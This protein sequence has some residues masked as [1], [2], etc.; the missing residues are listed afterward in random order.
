MRRSLL[1]VLIVLFVLVTIG[2]RGVAAGP[3]SDDLAKCLVGSTTVDERNMFVRWMFSVMA[4]HPAVKSVSAMTDAQRAELSQS[5]G[6]LYESLLTDRCRKEAQA[7]VKFEGTGTMQKAF[8]ALGR[9]AALELFS[10]EAVVAGLSDFAKYI[11]TKK[12][13]EALATQPVEQK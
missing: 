9:A 1:R 4:L 8:E 12:V 7:A 3:Y 6:K 2:S 10:H 13:E 5:V 11:D